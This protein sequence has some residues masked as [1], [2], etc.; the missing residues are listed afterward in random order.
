[1][2]AFDETRPGVAACAVGLALRAFD[3]AKKYSLERRTMGKFIA[4][5]RDVFTYKDRYTTLF[6]F[7]SLLKLFT[8]SGRCVYA[9]RD[10]HRY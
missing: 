3:E 5:V 8:A 2:G 10:G 9:C 6:C 7:N 4:E 1:M